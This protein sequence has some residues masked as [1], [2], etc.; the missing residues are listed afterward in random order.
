[1]VVK[2]LKVLN[3]YS[4]SKPY[5]LNSF[6]ISNIRKIITMEASDVILLIAKCSCI[7]AAV[8]GNGLVVA[9]VLARKKTREKKSNMCGVE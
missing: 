7:T 8:V 4:L 5:H 3:S 2:K 6:S 1:M 9:S